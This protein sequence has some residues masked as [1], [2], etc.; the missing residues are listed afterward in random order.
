[1]NHALEALPDIYRRLGTDAESGLS[2]EEA[3]RRL[4]ADGPNSFEA[5]KPESVLR[6]VLHHLRDFTS[7]ILI[8]AGAIA[9]YLGASSDHGFTDSLVIFAIVVLNVTLAVRQELG[10]ERALEALRRLN[11][12]QTVVLRGGERQPI[13]A[14][15]LVAG[16]IVSLAAGDL[17]PADTRIIESADLFVEESALTGESLPAEKDALAIVPADASL[18][19]QANM[20]FSGCLVTA[21]RCQAVVVA[22]GMSTEMGK[23]AGLLNNT[24]KTRTPLQLKMDKFGQLLCVIAL[25]SGGLLFLLQF[26]SEPLPVVLLN[27]VS[28][29]VAVIPECLPIIV[30]ISLAYGVANMARKQAIIRKMPA[31]ETLGSASVICSDKTGTLTQNR[32]AIQQIWAVGHDPKPAAAAFDPDEM[33]MLEMMGLANNASL[34][35]R[36]DEGEGA[37]L[38]ARGGESGGG[39]GGDLTIPAAV[40]DPTETAILRLLR[41]K[42]IEK[43]SLDAIFPRVFEIPFS[44][45]R[46]LMTTVHHADVDPAARY[47]SITK[48]AFD[49]M[50]IDAVSV[51]ADTAQQIHDAFAAEALRVLA[52]AYK[53][54]DSLPAELSPEELE[55]GLTFAGLIGMIDPPRPESRLAVQT[56]GEAGIRTVMI[57]GDHQATASAIAGEIGIL[58]EGGQVRSGVELAGLTDAEL[59][60]AVGSIS[61]YARVSP[62][63]KLR[64][65]AA[66]QANG[67]VVAMTGDGVNDAPALKAADVGVAMGSGTDVSKDA[68]D[69]VLTDDNFAS[70]VDAV[71]EGRRVYDNIRKVIWS[72]VSCNLSEIAIMLLAVLLWREAPLVAIQLLFI[73][74]VADGIPDLCISRESLEP[75]AMRRQPLPKDASIFAGGLG[76]RIALVA[77]VFAMVSL[78]AFY[79]GRFVP[80]SAAVAPSL[81][82]G[83]TMAYVV[84][85]WSSVVNIINVRSFHRSA[86]TNSFA[87]NRLLAAAI[88]FSLALVAFTAALPGLRDVFYCVQ[89]SWEHWLVMAGLSLTP[90]LAV[91]MEKI[92]LRRR[93]TT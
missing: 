78:V 57:T 38:V 66:W 10:A 54:F 85:G 9:L 92:W 15:G 53:Y 84:I 93:I 31:V 79:I 18:G 50:P 28:M 73:N 32:M 75:D 25:I 45:E 90:L 89:V 8:V 68:S 82:A 71:A 1:M 3:A 17:V 5:A 12:P 88:G 52:V 81:A 69:V 13:D 44:S 86:F 70:I 34:G 72:L 37:G 6:K 56:A 65:V 77:A 2:P 48:G 11:A 58:A 91:E 59:V 43:E 16:D 24:V 80:L 46:K 36:P 40:G 23:I 35:I 41:D 42:H 14:A 29:A 61:V 27:S 20:L 22:T 62:E 64:I 26:A 67:A 4:A 49:R 76:W 51:C 30:T 19:D 60:D 47:I 83:R 63:D 7:L 87:S 33:R 55:H 39:A 74:V 21:G